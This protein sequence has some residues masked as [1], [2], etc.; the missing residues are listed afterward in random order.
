MTD[1]FVLKPSVAYAA[2]QGGG[3]IAGFHE[4]N[5]LAP[6][7]LVAVDE[8]NNIIPANVTALDLQGVKKFRFYVGIDSQDPNA[9]TT[10]Y[11]R[12]SLLIDRFTLPFKKKAYDAPVKKVMRFGNDGVTSGASF[13][14]PTIIPGMEV[15]LRITR[16][17]DATHFSPTAYRGRQIGN[18][19]DSISV[20]YTT[21][22][23]D[24]AATIGTKLVA[25][26]NNHAG[27]TGDNKWIVAATI[28][29]PVSGVQL[30]AH[31]FFQDFDVTFDGI[32]TNSF[33]ITST[34]INFGSG[35]FTQVKELEEQDSTRRGN[36]SRREFADLFYRVASNHAAGVTGYVLYT[37]RWSL[38]GE[39][40]LATGDY[41]TL[42]DL[43]LGVPTG[44]AIVATIDDVIAAL[45]PLTV[46]VIEE[47]GG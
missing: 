11:P 2:K 37:H 7:A 27:N 14:F 30:T 18:M 34:A 42:N 24:T 5:L 8:N 15:F 17:Q 23:G 47:Q 21:I 38:S 22:V 19:I 3:T 16:R 35:Y 44:D 10:Q 4:I 29:N 9:V 31:H 25:L 40:H 33:K 28:G 13:N 43:I 39:N 45:T 26:I 20:S 1:V 12:K 46:T 32:L 6:G 36:T 41:G